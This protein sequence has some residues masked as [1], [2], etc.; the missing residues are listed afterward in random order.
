MLVPQKP[1][2]S[3]TP[4]QSGSVPDHESTKLLFQ[5]RQKLPLVTVLLLPVENGQWSRTKVVII[6]VQVSATVK[7]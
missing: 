5:L 3:D 6:T 7:K 4:L 2:T 1:G